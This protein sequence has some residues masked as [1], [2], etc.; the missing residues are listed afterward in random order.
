[1]I[2]SPLSTTTSEDGSDVVVH[3]VLLKPRPDLSQAERQALVRAFERAIRDIPTVRGVR[4][5]ERV[6]HG[7]GY[8]SEAPD[9][10]DYG[11]ILEF[12]DLEGLQAYLRHPAHEELG[13]RFNQS[14]SSAMVYDF[15]AGG[16]DALDRLV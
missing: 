6:R 11:V 9:W 16:I 10:V 8:E 12:D 14:L 3:L 1:M 5:G 4:V 7:A 13:A 2:T 15:E